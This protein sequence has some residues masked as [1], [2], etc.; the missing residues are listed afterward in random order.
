VSGLTNQLQFIL[1]SKLCIHSF[2]QA[3]ATSQSRYYIV[4]SLDNS[5]VLRVDIQNQLKNI[6]GFGW[7]KR[8]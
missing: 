5:F 2:P 6:D 1:L 4:L 7:T 3:K 8:G